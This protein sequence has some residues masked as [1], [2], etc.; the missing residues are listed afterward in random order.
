MN[1]TDEQLMAYADGELDEV[2][3]GEIAAAIAR[4]PALAARVQEHEALRARLQSTFGPVLEERIPDRLVAAVNV[5]SRDELTELR[6][7]RARKREQSRWSW[8]AWGAIAASLVMGI[9]IGRALFDADSSTLVERNGNLVASGALADALERNLS[10]EEGNHRIVLS[11]RSD[12]G[13]YCRAFSSRGDADVAGLACRA[14]DEWTIRTVSELD[15]G[16]QQYELA[17]SGLPASVL[18]AVDTHI[19][20][21]PL[22]IE[23][24]RAARQRGW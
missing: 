20:G 9:L 2:A 17:S 4:D 7:A 11:F 1:I 10:N 14:D 22:T 16:S 5:S 23:E 18:A 3:R 8:P 6:Q 24:E 12:D 13:T 21:E 19:D 15:S